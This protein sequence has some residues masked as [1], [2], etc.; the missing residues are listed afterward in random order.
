MYP[1]FIEALDTFTPKPIEIYNT[2]IG[3]YKWVAAVIEDN[4]YHA[5]EVFA[6]AVALDRTEPDFKR[7]VS[8]CKKVASLELQQSKAETTITINTKKDLVYE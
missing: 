3:A 7:L 2:Q 5:R 8:S 4:L 1:G 6:D